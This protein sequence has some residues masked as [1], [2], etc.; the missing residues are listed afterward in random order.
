MVSDVEVKN[1][2]VPGY[3][4]DDVVSL[5][6]EIIESHPDEILLLIGT[7]DL[8]LRRSVEHLVRNVESALVQLRRALPGAQ[9]LTQSIMPRAA[10]F[11]PSIQDANI[12]LR[13]FCPT[14]YAQYLDLWPAMATDDGS[15][16]PEFSDDELHLNA[17]GYEAWLDELR[18]GLERLRNLPP[19]SSPIRIIDV[20]TLPR[21]RR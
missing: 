14:V 11:A 19:M 4:S 20:E 6:D 21:R 5:L 7:N 3:T 1:F 13:Q 17:A 15:L 9:L 12:H 8:G 18:P 10:E 2:G 16:R